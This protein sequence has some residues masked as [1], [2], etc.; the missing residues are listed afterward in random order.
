MTFYTIDDIKRAV[1]LPNVDGRA[2]HWQMAPKPRPSKRPSSLSGT[3][4][5]GAVLLMV[6][7]LADELHVV[8]TRRPDTLN[9]HAGQISFPGGR[10]EGDETLQTTALRETFEEVGITDADLTVIGQLTP[11]YIP[12]SDFEVTPFVAWHHPPTRPA[13][14][15]SAAEVAE[16]L[17]V[18]LSQLLDPSTLQESERIFQ[19]Q[20][21]QVPFFN[22]DGHK[23]W[24]AT[25]M[26]LREFLT[27]LQLVR[28][29]PSL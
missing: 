10:Q 6:Y 21:F 2:I 16:I 11:L 26:M 1:A 19:G 4:R 29:L 23:V 25:A 12:P 3:A 18:P 8:L 9:T 20:S 15:P 5:I 13:F 27:R 22:V 17:E 7:P 24:G 28:A 14:Q